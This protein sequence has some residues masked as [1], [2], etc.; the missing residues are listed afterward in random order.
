M[1]VLSLST[2]IKSL[3]EYYAAIQTVGK[4]V[5]VH[6]V[7]EYH[8]NCPWCGGEDRFI[9]R[10]EEGTY[11]C[12]TRAS[13]CGRFGDMIT[14]LREYCEMSFRDACET[15][16]VDPSEL[17]DYTAS[18]NP[19]AQAY[20]PPNKTW[21]QRGDQIVARAQ[22]VL[23]STVGKDALA[24]LH[25]RGLT[26]DTIIEKQLGYIPLDARG[27][28]H[29]DD[30]EKWGLTKED[31]GKE[32]IW[33]YEG[34]L[35]PWYVGKKL[36]KLDVRRLNGLKKDDP[37]ILSITGS[38][39]CLYNHHTVK[40]GKPA[41]VCESA[42]CA[43]SGEQ[44]AGDRAAFVATGGASKHHS[45]WARHLE[46]A[47]VTLIALDL[48]EPDDNGKRPGDEGAVYWERNLSYQIR[49]HPYK[50]DINDMLVAGDNV[51]EWVEEGIGW[52]Y[53][54]EAAKEP[55]VVESKSCVP[56]P[57][58]E[59]LEHPAM[60][61]LSDTFFREESMEV[62][63]QEVV[64]LPEEAR[65]LFERLR[66][67]TLFN[68]RGNTFYRDQLIPLKGPRNFYDL[69]E[70]DL[71]SPDVATYQRALT[72]LKKKLAEVQQE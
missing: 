66:T 65:S 59:P 36:W 53:E 55:V 72:Q 23:R 34:I 19:S 20:G 7:L 50:K 6:S 47:T 18:S 25:A 35:I 68:M 21:Q 13:G 44:E 45:A 12:M 32:K 69:L 46:Q 40:S 9:T 28:W 63:S 52:Y 71:A 42:L 3:I 57:V 30:L 26:D 43:I 2:D 54:L 1:A 14:F 8:S 17:G 56:M 10:P 29:D 31:T 5:K 22:A 62:V 48:D 64:A 11:S 16:G 67:D 39:D 27:R 60:D 70:Q 49:W 58:E 61:E 41:F 15:I 33:L 37:K 4:P 38:I 24:Y 51:R